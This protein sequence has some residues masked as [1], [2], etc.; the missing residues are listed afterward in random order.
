MKYINRNK[1][2]LL[3]TVVLIV[4]TVLTTLSAQIKGDSLV[5]VAFNKAESRDLQG[6]IA[7]YNV[8]E[9]LEKNYFTGSLDGLQSQLAGMKG[10]SIWGQ[11]GLLLI[12]G[13][14]RSQY[15]VQPTEIENITVL[16]GANAVALYGSRAAKGVILITT[17]RGKEGALRIDVRANTGL[18]IPKAYPTY[19]NAAEYMT[20]YNEACLNL[21]LIHI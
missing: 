11:N 4:Q 21:S 20:L 3:V 18:H 12:D 19:L 15:D 13:V 6:G 17:K 1:N 7:S 2:Y 5:N 16:K 10:T 9:L 8:Q 14:P